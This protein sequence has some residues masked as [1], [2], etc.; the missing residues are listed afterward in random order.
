[1]GNLPKLIAE[2]TG[3][4]SSRSSVQE[5]QAI[6]EL[7]IAVRRLLGKTTEKQREHWDIPLVCYQ[8]SYLAKLDKLY[9]VPRKAEGTLGHSFS[10]LSRQL[11]RQVR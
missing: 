8:D 5:L 3:S 9:L 11:S 6:Q 10:L 7:P 4:C 2:S 1:M